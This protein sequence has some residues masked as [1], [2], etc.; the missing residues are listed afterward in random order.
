MFFN[1]TLWVVVV[2]IFACHSSLP[3]LAIEE[4]TEGFL[5]TEGSQKVLFYQRQPQSIEGK[6]TRCHYI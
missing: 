3:K 2:L 6:Y 5:F 4:T 1:H